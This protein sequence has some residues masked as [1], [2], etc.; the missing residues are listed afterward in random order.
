MKRFVF[1]LTIFIAVSLSLFSLDVLHVNAA[2]KVPEGSVI[3]N[4]I[5]IGDIDV[6]GLSSSEAKKLIKSKL[7]DRKA[8]EITVY[9]VD[10]ESVVLHP[11]DVGL[12]WANPETTDEAAS[13]GNR[14]NIIQRYKDRKDIAKDGIKLP[15]EYSVSEGAIRSFVEEQCSVFD[16]YAVDATMEKTSDGFSIV[17]G[18]EG[19]I[20]DQDS[21]V[22]YISDFLRNNWSGTGC[23]IELPIII[24]KPKGTEEDLSQV[25]DLLATFS[26]SF[27]T[28]GAD[29]SANV[30]NGCRLVNGTTLYPGDE[31]SM[32]DHIKPFTEE[33]GYHMA[34]S[35][36]NGLVVDSLGGGI[37]QVSTTL[38]NA[39]IRAELEVTER[40]N[41]SMVVTY[42]PVSQDA[43]ISESSGKDFR[44]VNNTDYPVFIEGYTT[45]EKRIIFNIYGKE[46][47]PDS[48]SV[49]FE[50]NILSTVVP[51]GEKIV[52]SSAYP[53]GYS[54]VQS[55]HTGYKAQLI[56]IVKENGVE[57]SREVF[58]SSTYNSVPRTAV[59][60]TSSNNP[61]AVAQIQEAIATGSIDYARSIAGA[62]AAA[63]TLVPTEVNP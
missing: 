5:T 39:V 58:N 50:T 41:H 49:E 18:S 52:P 3:A 51:E 17:P 2:S 62:W 7:E 46:T 54:S 28:S 59:I 15:L 13:Y 27:S 11:G 53:V 35:Y 33:N 38:Y 34:G 48:R 31:F 19:A 60:G 14:G 40:N 26:T 42:V 21:A 6:S 63:A 24:D 25:K 45:D 30:R 22:S 29:R 16:H 44:F 20:V 61:D 56:K 55:A 23:E 57:V 32:Y 12:D 1:N 9:C 10:N 36:V 8:A 37:C 4:G 43:A 47:R